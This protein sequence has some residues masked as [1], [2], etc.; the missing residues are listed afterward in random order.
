MKNIERTLVILKPDSVQRS[1]IGEIISR[2]ERSGLKIIAM[3][4]IAP[5]KNTVEK[6]YTVD[7]NWKVKTGNKVLESRD[8]K[9]T[10]EKAGQKVLDSLLEY[11]TAGPVVAAVVEGA[12][13]VSLVRKLVGGTEPLT[14]D[15]GTIRGDYVIDSYE[16][17]D[18]SNRSIRNLI[19]ASS[20]LED[21]DKEI[22][23]WFD[24]S[25]IIKYRTAQEDILYRDIYAFE[26]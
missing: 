11:M 9:L 1:L 3:K 2:F 22:K 14:S 16:M 18:G 6:H 19:H 10:P 5:D 24:E 13:S 4:M 26:K 20:S 21:A 8:V 12:H 25:D 7:P 17:A 15:V 23:I